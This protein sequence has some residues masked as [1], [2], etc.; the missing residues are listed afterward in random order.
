[1]QN[2]WV[3]LFIYLRYFNAKWAIVWEFLFIISILTNFYTI[4]DCVCTYV[5]ILWINKKYIKTRYFTCNISLS[6]KKWGKLLFISPGACSAGKFLNYG[7]LKRHFLHFEGTLEQNIKVLNDILLQRTSSFW[8]IISVQ[9]KLDFQFAYYFNKV[10]E[11][12]DAVVNFT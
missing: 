2:R 4:F 9:M 1:M 6:C 7:S 12:I 11:N 10:W 3:K 8:T 5:N